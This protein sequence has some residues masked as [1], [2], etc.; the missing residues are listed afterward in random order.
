MYFAKRSNFA[1]I[2]AE[3][4]YL[5]HRYERCFL[6]N[7]LKYGRYKD[8]SDNYHI[9]TW[10][11]QTLLGSQLA[12]SFATKAELERGLF[13][14]EDSEKQHRLKLMLDDFFQKVYVCQSNQKV[15]L[16]WAL[17]C[18]IGGKSGKI[19]QSQLKESQIN[20]LWIASTAIA[21]E[22][23]LVGQEKDFLWMQDQGLTLI[24]YPSPALSAPPR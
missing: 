18:N 5:H 21:Y 13:K 7:E 9:A 12:I 3:H 22:L 11:A 4:A 10:Y 16:A 20:D 23:P 2:R 8:E 14:V 24:R 17:L 1:K 19:N 6:S 15:S